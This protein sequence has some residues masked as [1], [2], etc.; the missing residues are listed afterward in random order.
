MIYS[1][2]GSQSDINTDGKILFIEDL[3]EYLYHIDRIM[4]NLKRSGKLDNLAGL[5]IGGMNDMNDNKIAFG[6]T[7]IEIISEHVSE[8][9]YPV[10][11]NF[12]AGHRKKN[13]AL[14]LG[15]EATLEVNRKVNLVFKSKTINLKS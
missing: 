12:P 9:N 5:I 15:R 8:Y 10:C 2:I 3:D 14:I 7:A 11:F 4:M 6:K 13:Y 1:L